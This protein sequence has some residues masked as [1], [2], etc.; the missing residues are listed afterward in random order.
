MIPKSHQD[1]SSNWS[2]VIDQQAELRYIRESL[3][4]FSHIKGIKLYYT[5]LL[6]PDIA[7]LWKTRLQWTKIRK[8]ASEEK[9]NGLKPS[10][11]QRQFSNQAC[12]TFLPT[13][14][15]CIVWYFFNSPWRYKLLN[16]VMQVKL[17]FKE[18]IN[19]SLLSKLRYDGFKRYTMLNLIFMNCETRFFFQDNILGFLLKF[20]SPENNS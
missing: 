20:V 17:L 4:K 3:I 9:R 5:Y 11:F 10:L 14:A 16:N 18:K 1:F 8:Q 12:S 15:W 7:F 6:F 13:L 19:L 2:W